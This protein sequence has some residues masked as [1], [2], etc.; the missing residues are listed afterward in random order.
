MIMRN[1]VRV[2]IYP[3]TLAEP[4]KKAEHLV[5]MQAERDCRRYIPHKSGRLVSSGRVQNNKIIWEAPYARIM[6]FGKVYVDPDTNAG[7]YPRKDGTFYSRKG[8][9]KVRSDRDFHFGSGGPLWF[10]RARD[11]N[12]QK[13]LAIGKGAFGRA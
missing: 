1:S 3:D 2:V 6:W 8:V 11:A 7:G 10:I 13:W 5:A 4:C 9:Q 12:L